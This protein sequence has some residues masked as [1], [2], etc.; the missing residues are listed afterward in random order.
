MCIICVKPV[1]TGFPSYDMMERCFDNNSD[2]A[3]YMLAV[4]GSVLIRKGFMKF[5]DFEESLMEDREMYGDN[6]CYVL[7]FRISTQAG[8]NKECCHPYP[9]TSDMSRMKK[10]MTGCDI[11]FAHNGILKAY[12]DGSKNYNDTMLFNQ[13]F[14]SEVVRKPKWYKNKDLVKAVADE[15]AGSRLAIL[16]SDGHCEMTGS[17]IQEGGV[18]YSNMGYMDGPFDGYIK[19]TNR[20]N[21]CYYGPYDDYYDYYT[22]WDAYKFGDNRYDFE[23]SWC[24]ASVDMNMDYCS[25]CISRD[26]CMEKGII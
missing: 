10:L 16:S 23:P 24:P 19:P 9:V 11:G 18:F 7:H 20:R 14:L 22:E 1:D 8:V 2:G 4:N 13:R 12:S 6:P 25:M 26:E 5:D 21:E 15:S 3:G 17:W